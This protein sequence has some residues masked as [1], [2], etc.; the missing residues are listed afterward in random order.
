[1]C[2]LMEKYTNEAEKKGEERLAKL[3]TELAKENRTNDIV[4]AGINPKKRDMLY[5]EFGL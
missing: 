1:M 4:E 3:I 5:K 2:E